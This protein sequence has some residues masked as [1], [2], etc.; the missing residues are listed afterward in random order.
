[1]DTRNHGEKS[2]SRSLDTTT[3]D[4]R[5]QRAMKTENDSGIETPELHGKW[6]T[7][8]HKDLCFQ[9]HWSSQ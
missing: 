1:M 7:S 3:R 4:E 8:L 2:T 5:T 6:Q 9:F